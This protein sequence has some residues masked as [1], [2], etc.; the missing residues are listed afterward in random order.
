LPSIRA[1]A[2]QLGVI[3]NTVVLAYDK[4]ASSG[5]IDPRGTAGCSVCEPCLAASN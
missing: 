1:P 5:L 3:P 4:L 2:T